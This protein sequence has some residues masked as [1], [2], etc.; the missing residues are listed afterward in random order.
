LTIETCVILEGNLK[1][2]S[3]II[4]TRKS[5]VPQTKEHTEKYKDKITKIQSKYGALHVSL[6]WGI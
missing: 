1:N 2:I 5:K 4:Q 6:F 3:G